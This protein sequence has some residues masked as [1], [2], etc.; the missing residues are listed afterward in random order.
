MKLLGKRLLIKRDE[1]IKQYSSFLFIPDKHIEK[2]NTGVV[3]QIGIDADKK[4]DNK[5]VM[6]NPN[7]GVPFDESLL[8]FTLDV[9]AIL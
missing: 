3:Q 2:R 4:F 9:I 8:I 1:P 6:F 5:R 7:A